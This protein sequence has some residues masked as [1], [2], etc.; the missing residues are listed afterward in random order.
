MMTK[1]RIHIFL[2]NHKLHILGQENRSHI[3]TLYVTTVE[4]LYQSILCSNSSSWA[5]YKFCWICFNYF[6]KKITVFIIIIN[7]EVGM[8]NF[9]QSVVKLPNYVPFLELSFRNYN[10]LGCHNNFQDFIGT[11]VIFNHNFP[12]FIQAIM[13]EKLLCDYE[14]PQIVVISLKNCMMPSDNPKIGWLIDI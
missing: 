3:F 14:I 5:Q 9:F 2:L 10:F 11:V 8:S 1:Y 4:Y 13:I 7:I 12:H 6:K